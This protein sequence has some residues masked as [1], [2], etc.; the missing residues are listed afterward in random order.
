[1]KVS[2]LPNRDLHPVDEFC[3]LV[4][5]ISRTTFYELVKAGRLRTVKL[6]SRT[7]VSRAERERFLSS[8]TREAA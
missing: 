3:A 8:L 1:M 6:G 5:N 7:Y 2:P 4:G